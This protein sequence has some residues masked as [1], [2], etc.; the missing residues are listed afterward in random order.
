MIDVVRIDDLAGKP[1]AVVMSASCHTIV[2]GPKTLS[3][4]PDY[5]GP[6]RELIEP[7]IGAPSLFL[8]GRPGTSTPRVA[9]AAAERSSLK[10]CIGWDDPRR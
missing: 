1:I 2:L 7:A 6:A 9:L 5:I 10:T 4:S 8:R 3:Y